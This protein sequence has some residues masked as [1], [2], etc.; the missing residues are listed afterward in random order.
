VERDK[1]TAVLAAGKACLAY[2]AMTD[3]NVRD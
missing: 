1:C 3:V 2:A